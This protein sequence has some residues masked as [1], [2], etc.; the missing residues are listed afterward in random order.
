MWRTV[1][2]YAL[3][4]AVAAVALEQLKFRYAADEISTDVY[5]GLLALGFT[6]LGLWVGHRLTAKKPAAPFER[7]NAAIASLGLTPRECEILDLLASGRTNQ[8]LA[9]VLGVSPNTVKTHLA[10][11]FA[12][13]EVDRRVK[14]IEKARFLALIE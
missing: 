6:V 10:N 11:L 4:L 8:E 13:L 5:V 7:N 1:I 2:L 12:K 14:A 3:G 9:H